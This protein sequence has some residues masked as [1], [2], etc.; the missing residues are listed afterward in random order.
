MTS[1][2]RIFS[3]TVLLIHKAREKQTERENDRQRL[4]A[5]AAQRSGNEGLRKRKIHGICVQPCVYV[6][7][8][9]MN[10]LINL[11]LIVLHLC[12]GGVDENSEKIL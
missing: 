3:P 1:H 7:I 5:A 12:R 11:L 10:L 8:H 4:T 9:D 6:Q 2:T